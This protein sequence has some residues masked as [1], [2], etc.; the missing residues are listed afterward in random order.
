MSPVGAMLGHPSGP[1]TS[2]S[3]S[4]SFFQNLLETAWVQRRGHPSGHVLVDMVRGAGP[5]EG[6]VGVWRRR[7]S[8]S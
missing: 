8:E 3:H 1:T 4:T 2:L 5:H 7:G 6:G